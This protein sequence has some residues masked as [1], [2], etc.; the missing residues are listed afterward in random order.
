MYFRISVANAKK[1]YYAGLHRFL[2]FSLYTVKPVLS[3][4]SRE[5]PTLFE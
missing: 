2:M 4:L 5:G 1:E 3:K